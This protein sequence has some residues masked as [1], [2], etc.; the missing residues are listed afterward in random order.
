MRTVA[1]APLAISLGPTSS[2]AIGL[3]RARGLI[4]LSL[5]VGEHRNVEALAAAEVGS[6]PGGRLAD[7]H[8]APAGRL[9][10]VAGAIQLDRVLLAENSAVVT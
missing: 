6:L 5:L 10:L 3:L 7:Q 8:E 4:A 1:R 9:E 2:L